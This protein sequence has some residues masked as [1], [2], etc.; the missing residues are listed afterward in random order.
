[1]LN[2]WFYTEKNKNINTQ[3]ASLTIRI[4]ISFFPNIRSHSRENASP[5]VY[6]WWRQGIAR[7]REK[8]SKASKNTRRRAGRRTLRK[9]RGWRLGD[10][11]PMEQPKSAEKDY[12]ISL[13]LAAGRHGK[14]CHRMPS[15][16][17]LTQWRTRVGVDFVRFSCSRSG[18]TCFRGCFVTKKAYKKRVVP[19][20]AQ[21][22]RKSGRSPPCHPAA[23]HRVSHPVPIRLGHVPLVCPF[24]LWLR[25]NFGYISGTCCHGSAEPRKWLAN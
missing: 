17:V 21:V 7:T 9:R 14:A 22:R 6:A 1:M 10:P 18:T 8:K 4:R 3:I 2:Y 13:A 12:N 20:A 11:Q 15:G 24:W 25:A 19:F 16:L 5:M 23:V